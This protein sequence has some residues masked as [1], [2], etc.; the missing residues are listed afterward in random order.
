P[1]VVAHAAT[2]G[3]LPAH[4]GHT[5]DLT[6]EADAIA[7]QSTIPPITGMCPDNL[8]YI[9]YTSGSTGIPKG[10]MGV[11]RV[12]VSRLHWDATGSEGDET[13]AQKTTPNFIDMIWETF[14]PLIRGQRLI[15]IP[16]DVT[17]D[18][19]RLI[20]LLSAQNATRIMLVPSLLRAMLE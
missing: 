5:V 12:A 9:L 18:P 11:H 2:R 10:V 17:R 20:A 1:V 14:M 7:A 3:R 19:E 16:E 6:E 4:P 13:Y 15:V 8:A